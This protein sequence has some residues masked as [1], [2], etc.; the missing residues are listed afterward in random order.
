MKKLRRFLPVLILIL[1]LIVV[2]APARNNSANTALPE[3]TAGIAA[4]AE[5]GTTTAD[6]GGELQLLEPS[7]SGSAESP[8]ESAAGQSSEP[9]KPAEAEHGFISEDAADIFERKDHDEAAGDIFLRKDHDEAVADIFEQKDHEESA[10]LVFIKEDQEALPEAKQEKPVQASEASSM[11]SAELKLE[12]FQEIMTRIIGKA[13]ESNN[14]SLSSSISSEV[15][16]KVTDRVIKQ[17]DYLMRENEEREEE[18]FRKLDETIRQR[19][20]ANAE[21]AAALVEES[22]KKKKLRFGRRD[23]IKHRIL[24]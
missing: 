8:Q 24:S 12:Q 2:L 6:A 5:P 15:S 10:D 23:K 14:K 20:K 4:T 18:R 9:E 21:A 13:L 16:D 11:M 19:Q 1:A 17:M 7:G 22:K 3:Q